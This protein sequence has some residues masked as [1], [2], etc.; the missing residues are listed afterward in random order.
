MTTHLSQSGVGPTQRPRSTAGAAGS[1]LALTT[2]LL[3]SLAGCA[4]SPT[5]QAPADQRLQ[6]AAVP[7]TLPVGAGAPADTAP[8]AWRDWVQ[9]PILVQ[10]VTL[11]LQN[12]R[13]LRV[14][15]LNVQRAQAQL[16]VADASRLPTLG[17]GGQCRPGAQ[18]QGRRGH[19]LDRR[20]AGHRLGA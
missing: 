12:N 5:A 1:R 3:A 19:H 9:A 20:A 17:A 13:D 7:A 6:Q 2:L 15:L 8:L 4:S 18:R 10:W 16:T 14:A 11:A